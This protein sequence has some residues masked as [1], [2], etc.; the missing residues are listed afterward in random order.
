MAGGQTQ[1]G[2]LDRRVT[3]ERATRT[4]NAFNEDVDVWSTLTTVA[5]RRMDVSDAESYRAQE[6]GATISTR[7]LVRWSTLIDTVTPVDRLVFKGDVYNITAVREPAGTRNQWRE[8]SAV[9]RAD[10]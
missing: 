2:D 6:V 7:F 4:P 8:I 3:I 9:K 1:A 5:A 10:K